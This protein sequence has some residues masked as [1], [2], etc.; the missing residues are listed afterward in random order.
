MMQINRI[1]LGFLTV[2]VGLTALVIMLTG[3]TGCRP[4]ERGLRPAP[5]GAVQLQPPVAPVA[6]DTLEMHGYT[7]VDPYAWMMDMGRDDPQTIAYV[8]AENA[9]TEARMR[10]TEE[11]QEDLFR[12][13]RARIKETDLSVPVQ[14][15]EYY[16]YARTQEGEDYPI[17]CRKRGSL[18]AAEEVTL[19]VNVLAAGREF[20]QVGDVDYSPDHRFVA[21]T[22]DT[23]G[24]E[25]YSLRVKDLQTGEFLPDD[26]YPLFSFVWANDNQTIFYVRK[27]D[28]EIESPYQCF[29]HHLRDPQSRD[30]LIYQEDDLA[31]GLGVTKSR[32]DAYIFLLAGDNETAE[33]RFLPADNPRGEFRMLQ[34]RDPGVEYSVHHWEEEFFFLTNGDGAKNFKIMRTAIDHPEPEHWREFIGHRDAV[35]ITGFDVFKN[36]FAI[37]ERVR[38][39]EKIRVIDM[40][41]GAE[42]YVSFPEP[43]YSF[44]TRGNPNYESEKYRFTYFSLVT[45][46][47]VYDYDFA[48]REMEL[49]KQSEVRGGFDPHDYRSEYFFAQ[50]RDGAQIPM[51]IVYRRDR[52]RADGSNPLYLYAYGSYGMGSA[53]YFSSVRLSLLDRGFI[54]VIAHI[55]GGDEMGKAWHDQGKLL[56]KKNT[57]YDFIDC[58]EYLIRLNYTSSDRLVINGGSAGGMLMGAVANMRPD[59]F[60]IVIANVPAVDMLHTMLDP[61]IPGTVFH[62]TELGNPNL[63]EHFEYMRSWDPYTNV[64]RQRYPTMLVTAGL[65]DP[66]VGYWE[67]AKWVAR[68]RQE[69]LGDEWLLLKTD[70]SGHMGASGRY[71]YLRQLAFEYAFLFD[72]LGLEEARR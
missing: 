51:S 36:W 18:D 7:W 48:T 24:A 14:E 35:Y 50:G 5:A 21:F 41:S 29:R 12:E 34:P 9:Y 57:F 72:R 20:Y 8:E 37:H 23:T 68:L 62:Y 56:N 17:Y 31:Y 40:R 11:L 52:F 54:Y 28:P 43:T 44:F 15:D 63:R 59:L 71:D 1:W 3:G 47:S 19:D 16:Y 4:A 61:T 70:M 60:E 27:L 67:P 42:H 46:R 55:R 58:A 6:P 45:P 64:R 26:V 30:E 25:R 39:L 22:V 66:R 49:L 53:V 65:H 10:P 69:K 38:G 32:S 33:W 13:M 2:A